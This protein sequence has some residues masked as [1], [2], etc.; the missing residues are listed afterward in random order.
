MKAY[1]RRVAIS[2]AALFL[3]IA[4]VAPVISASD[5]TIVGGAPAGNTAD[6]I[7]QDPYA[8]VEPI[9]EANGEYVYA[10]GAP[11]SS[12]DDNIAPVEPVYET[13]D[14]KPEPG[15]EIH[16]EP[17]QEPEEISAAMLKEDED[18]TSPDFSEP[19]KKNDKGKSTPPAIGF[20]R[21]L[22]RKVQ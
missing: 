12:T 1:L 19:A 6:S 22:L 13:D 20:W 3:L 17:I 14:E 8:P 9:Y 18:P 11:A 7:A 16:T 15:Q 10:D 4:L 2:A 5:Y 21:N